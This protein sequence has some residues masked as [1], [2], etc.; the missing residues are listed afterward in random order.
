MTASAQKQRRI[1][2]RTVDAAGRHNTSASEVHF[3]VAGNTRLRIRKGLDCD[4]GYAYLS[5]QVARRPQDLRLHMQRIFL[6]VDSK[7]KDR[8]PGALVDLFIVLGAAGQALKKRCLK[9]ATGLLDGAARRLL[10]SAVNRGIRP[11]DPALSRYRGTVLSLGFTGTP[12]LVT[13]RQQRQGAG[14]QSVFEEASACLEYGQLDEARR[15]LEEG[16]NQQNDDPRLLELLLEIYQRC[17][18]KPAI[19]AMRARLRDRGVTPDDHA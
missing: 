10:E 4:R 9:L 15:V 2:R 11:D 14:Y 16:V 17:D 8:L 6:L 12:M 3:R 7:Q 18:D 1:V 5:Q 19:D 13:R